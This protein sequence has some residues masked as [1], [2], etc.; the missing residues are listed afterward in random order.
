MST[1]NITLYNT[2][3]QNKKC[4]M[5]SVYNRQETDDIKLNVCAPSLIRQT[6]LWDK[7]NEERTKVMRNKKQKYFLNVIDVVQN[8]KQPVHLANN[9]SLLISVHSTSIKDNTLEFLLEQCFT[10]C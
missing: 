5:D 3:E 7:K 8:I 10:L 2:V 4:D 6:D 9:Y 1:V